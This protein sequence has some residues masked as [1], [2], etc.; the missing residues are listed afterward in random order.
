MFLA[1]SE[2]RVRHRR[3]YSRDK[4]ALNVEPPNI[5]QDA[6]DQEMQ[7]RSAVPISF[8]YIFLS[9]ASLPSTFHGPSAHTV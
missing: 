1:H 8:Q 3:S 5:L 2:T 4:M 6:H 7:T 9:N